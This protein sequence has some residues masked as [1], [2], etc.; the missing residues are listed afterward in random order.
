MDPLKWAVKINK[1]MNRENQHLPRP[2]HAFYRCRDGVSQDLIIYG[3]KK[4]E[5]AKL[6]QHEDGSAPLRVGPAAARDDSVHVVWPR[7]VGMVPA[8]YV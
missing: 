6:I 7:L 5:Q 8:A 3:H 1:R 4:L 2:L